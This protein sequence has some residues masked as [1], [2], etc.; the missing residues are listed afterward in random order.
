MTVTTETGLT[1]VTSGAQAAA[2]AAVTRAGIQLA[3]S[4]RRAEAQPNRRYLAER[5]PTIA[6][7]G[8]IAAAQAGED[9]AGRGKIVAVERGPGPFGLMM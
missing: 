5:W 2:S 8:R 4:S 6:Q 9:S 3:T 7:P 1:L